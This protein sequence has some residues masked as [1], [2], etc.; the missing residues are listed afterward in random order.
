MIGGKGRHSL[1]VVLLCAGALFAAGCQRGFRALEESV[2]LGP[3]LVGGDRDPVARKTVS[4]RNPT[5]E[6]LELVRAITSCGCLRAHI[7]PG[8][9]K[10][11]EARDLELLYLPTQP[12]VSVDQLR[13]AV[14]TRNGPTWWIAVR[15]TTFARLAVLPRVIRFGEPLVGQKAEATLRVRIRHEVDEK[16]PLKLVQVAVRHGVVTVEDLGR[17]G[18]DRDGPFLLVEHKFRVSLPPDSPPGPGTDEVILTFDREVRLSRHDPPQRTVAVLAQWN[19]LPLV[20]VSPGSLTL[21]PDEPQTVRVRKHIPSSIRLVRVTVDPPTPG[22]SITPSCP[23][24]LPV[25]LSLRWSPA[26]PPLQ[27]RRLVRLTVHTDA[28]LQPTVQVLVL[29]VGPGSHEF[30]NVAPAN[31]PEQPHAEEVRE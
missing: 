25:T 5:S 23:V 13:L 6:T 20:S 28:S 4:L 17:T 3:I 26:N 2:A 16:D 19:R 12:E 7:D 14:R 11:G 9:L 27:S 24:S 29:L 30:G 1:V 18:P 15:A 21:R 22:L 10:P 8:P 31:S